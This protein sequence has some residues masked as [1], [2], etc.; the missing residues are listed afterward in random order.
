MPVERLHPLVLGRDLVSRGRIIDGNSVSY[1]SIANCVDSVVYDSSFKRDPGCT[2]KYDS[3]V[4]CLM[5]DG[6][7]RDVCCVLERVEDA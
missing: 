3:K 2:V 1:A 5:D 7:V 6:S 4:Q